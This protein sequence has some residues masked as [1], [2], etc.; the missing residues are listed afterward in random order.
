MKNEKALEDLYDYCRWNDNES[1]KDILEQS[2]EAID[3]LD[4]KGLFF[5]LAISANNIK[6]LN[7]LLDYYV[8][9]QYHSNSENQYAIPFAKH[10][11]QM[12]LQEAVNKFDVSK[13]MQE[14]LNPYLPKEEGNDLEQELGDIIGFNLS[15]IDD[16]EQIIDHHDKPLIGDKLIDIH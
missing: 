4:D 10:K 9:T 7:V 11:L 2:S 3:I 12:I 16:N 5:R 15:Q 1:V 8:K 14:I 6:M 13:E